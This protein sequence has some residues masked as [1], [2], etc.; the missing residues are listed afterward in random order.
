[1][2]AE[3]YLLD[4]ILKNDISVEKIQKEVGLNIVSICEKKK[5]LS[6]DEFVQ[7]CMYLG[8]NPDD[9]MGSII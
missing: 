8:I 3:Q 5:E 1:M 2:K 9:V 4:Y 7:L 6:A